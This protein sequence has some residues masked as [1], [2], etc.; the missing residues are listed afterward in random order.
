MIMTIPTTTSTLVINSLGSN[1]FLV[2]RGSTNEVNSAVVDKKTSAI[3]TLDLMMAS[4]KQYQCN[5]INTPFPNNFKIFL[6][7][8]RICCFTTI[9]YTRRVVQPINILQNTISTLLRL[10]SS[11]NFPIIPVNPQTKMVK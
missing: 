11:K 3:E 5:P 10:L 2:I 6:D 9:R 4:K 8:I 7:S 1:F